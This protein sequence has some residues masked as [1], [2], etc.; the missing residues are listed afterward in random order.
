MLVWLSSVASADTR[1]Q[2]DKGVLDLK[3]ANRCQGPSSTRMLLGL[4]GKRP[5]IVVR[6]D[7]DGNNHMALVSASSPRG[8]VPADPPWEAD[9]TFGMTGSWK[10]MGDDDRRLTITLDP[11]ARCRNDQ[12]GLTIGLVERKDEKVV[13]AERWKGYGVLM[14]PT[15]PGIHAITPTGS[16]P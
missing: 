7:A 5:V 10:L 14:R 6:V 15:V 4:T 9:D 16:K 8:D 12:I 3:L 11:L 13:C 2:V 1:Y